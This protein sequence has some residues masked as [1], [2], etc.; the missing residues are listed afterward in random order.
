MV[1]ARLFGAWNCT[2][3]STQSAINCSKFT[4][5]TVEQG[6]NEICSKLTIKTPELHQW[7]HFGVF[8]VNFEHILYIVIVNSEQ[9]IFFCFSLM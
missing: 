9:V 6:V 2:S 3:D 7:R 5:V 8:I 4:V 1:S